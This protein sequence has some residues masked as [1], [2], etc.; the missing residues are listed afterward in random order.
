MATHWPAPAR[1]SAPGWGHLPCDVVLASLAIPAADVD[2][3]DHA[4][5]GDEDVPWCDVAVHDAALV[6]AVEAGGR[7]LQQPGDIV[8]AKWTLVPDH[9]LKRF[10]LQVFHHDVWR[11][12]VFTEVQDLDDVRVGESRAKGGIAAELLPHCRSA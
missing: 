10:A 5:L 6:S 2:Q 11:A 9:I 12:R 7:L 8:R 3:F 1:R 4:R